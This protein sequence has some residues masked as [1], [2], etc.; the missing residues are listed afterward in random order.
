MTPTTPSNTAIRSRRV[1]AAWPVAVVCLASLSACSMLQED[2]VDYTSAK[3]VSTLEVPPDLTQL[4][5]ESR[6]AMPGSIVTAT[7]YQASAPKQTVSTAA[8]EVGDV[9]IERAG[10]QRWIVVKRPAEKLWQPVRDFWQENGFVLIQDQE[11][12]GLMET[13]W[14]ENR[15]KLPQDFIRNALGKMLDS[16]YSTGERDKFRTRIERNAA[17]ETE[18]Y[19]SHRGMVEVY[20]D[21][22]KDTTTWQPRAADTSLETEFLRRLMVKLGVSQEV[23]KAQAASAPPQSRARL[24]GAAGAATAVEVDDS[25]DRAWRR[26]GLALDRTGFTVED[27][28]RA[29]G[30][31]FV[32]YVEPTDPAAKEPGFLSKLFTSS[33]PDAKPQ[34]YRVQ[35]Q[36][37]D[38]LT[39]LVVQNAQGGADTTGTAARI[40]KLLADDLQ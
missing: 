16:L 38:R 6:Y 5:R 17:G 7:G 19:V 31:Y 1:G 28:D 26:V 20:A 30:I 23:A 39:T 9:R 8:T 22:A 11:A 35:L 4:N 24:V 14:A 10:N 37:N 29:K 12:L 36:G 32:R 27:R 40:M 34:Q 15:A 25:F 3:R 18:I 33:K 13:D 21:K 2:K